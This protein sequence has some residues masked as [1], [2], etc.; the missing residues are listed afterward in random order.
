MDEKDYLIRKQ[1]CYINSNNF[2]LSICLRHLNSIREE[3]IRFC[4]DGYHQIHNKC[5]SKQINFY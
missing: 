2:A 3:K 1:N 4:C 5:E